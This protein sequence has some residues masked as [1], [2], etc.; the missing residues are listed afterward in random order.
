[1]SF[2][3]SSLIFRIVN[4]TS[5]SMLEDDIK[6]NKSCAWAL[7]SLAY[8]MASLTQKLKTLVNSLSGS[9]TSSKLTKEKEPSHR[10]AINEC[11]YKIIKAN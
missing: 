6:T 9:G 11:W 1:M 7:F 4:V 3:I 8:C 2:T 10:E 5:D